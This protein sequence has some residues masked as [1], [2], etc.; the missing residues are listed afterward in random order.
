MSTAFAEWTR[1]WSV[2]SS[3]ILAGL[4]TLAVL[5]IGSLVGHDA[6]LSAKGCTD[7]VSD[8]DFHV[9]SFVLS[10]SAVSES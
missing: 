3:W 4:T 2:R 7:G 5:G 10:S 9:Q 8:I 1:V 6:Y